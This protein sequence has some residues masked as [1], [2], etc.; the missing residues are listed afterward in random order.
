MER[1]DSQDRYVVRAVARA[2]DILDV[3]QGAP[4]GA[5]LATLSGAV[6]LPKSSV[7]R[8][9]TTLLVRGYVQQDSATGTYR[10]GLGFAPIHTRN[11]QV[12]GA[13]ARPLLAEL[14]DRFDETI[15]LAVLHGNRIAY[16]E[17]LESTKA[18]RL[19]A[20]VG[21]HVPVHS[22]ALGKAICAT[23]PDSDVVEILK[24]EGMPRLTA[25]TVTDVEAF[26]AQ[27]E[28]VRRTGRAIDDR[29]HEEDGRCVAVAVPGTRIRAAISLS[30]PAMRF[31]L[32]DAD[33]VARA[34][35]E[36][37]AQLAG[38]RREAE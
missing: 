4:D 36:K 16:L 1:P 11:L 29:E 9:V 18:M 27:L 3:L 2:L 7:F 24:A 38:A 21:D 19:A 12:L 26:L 15:N 22:S 32:G 30:A 33:A 35:A 17:I 10:L 25:N 8:Y 5:S 28:E 37:A 6:H 13:R 31:P 34:L 20:R 23:L 14:R